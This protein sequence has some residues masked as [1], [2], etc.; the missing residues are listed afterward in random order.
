MRNCLTAGLIILLCLLTAAC[1]NRKLDK[2]YFHRYFHDRIGE[3]QQ[4]YSIS[5][6]RMPQGVQGF[7]IDSYYSIPDLE[8]PDGPRVTLLPPGSLM[9][10]QEKDKQAK[11][12]AKQAA[13]QA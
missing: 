10:Q 3:Y 12:L 5:P 4:S 1:E 7:K 11:K 8:N 2:D 13:Q 6:L 9:L